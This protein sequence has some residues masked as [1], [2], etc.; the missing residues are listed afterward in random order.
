MTHTA[1][2]PAC[3]TRRATGRS[4]R[5]SVLAMCTAFLAV[6]LTFAGI[7][8]PQSADAATVM[9]EQCEGIDNVGGAGVE[10]NVTVTNEY[11]TTTGVTSSIVVTTICVGPRGATTCGTPTTVSSRDIV[12]RV[13][14]CNGSGNGGGGEVECHVNVVNNIIGTGSTTPATINQ[15]VESGTGGGTAP[16]LNCAPESTTNADI[17]QCNQSV[18][19][20][21]DTMRVNCTVLPST[22][23]SLWPVTIEQC[24]G[25]A[26]GGGGYMTCSAQITNNIVPSA[27]ASS[28]PGDTTATT[29]PGS[30]TTVA[31]GGTTPGA[32]NTVPGTP[33][34][35]DSVDVDIASTS[36]IFTPTDITLPATGTGSLVS[37][38]GVGF[39]V[40][41]VGLAALVLA[42]RRQPA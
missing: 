31:G 4:H 39:A 35:G 1:S 32:G 38:S 20:G 21:G 23:T 6:G 37:Q 29:T 5:F 30:D 42:R 9:L 2:S 28:T 36:S 40:L 26:N 11:D 34:T 33:G 41:L 12:N 3:D 7:G 19:G 27:P 18:Q 22:T 8:T 17:T 13:E 24:V 10:C 16:T 14:Q 25:S 15:C